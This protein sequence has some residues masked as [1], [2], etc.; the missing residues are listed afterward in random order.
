MDG[1]LGV[2][3]LGGCTVLQQSLVNDASQRKQSI[4]PRLGSLGGLE[5]N[6]NFLLAGWFLKVVCIVLKNRMQE[7]ENVLFRLCLLFRCKIMD[8]SLSLVEL[9]GAC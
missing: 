9:L 1:V 4:H 6:L 2:Y 7:R 8:L 5:T 3:A